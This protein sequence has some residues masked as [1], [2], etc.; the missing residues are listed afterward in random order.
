MGS[1]CPTPFIL[2]LR[3]GVRLSNKNK[4]PVKALPRFFDIRFT[5]IYFVPHLL[6]R[7]TYVALGWSMVF[8]STNVTLR[9]HK[10]GFLFAYC[11]FLNCLFGQSNDRL[12]YRFSRACHRIPFDIIAL[13]TLISTNVIHSFVFRHLIDSKLI[14]KHDGTHTRCDTFGETASLLHNSTVEY[15]KRNTEQRT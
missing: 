10:A 3:N 13:A 9:I 2:I 11:V 6:Y 5:E 4:R 8:I 1:N 14:Q 15:A 7:V 12:C